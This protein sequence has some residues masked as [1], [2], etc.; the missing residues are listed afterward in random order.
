[1]NDHT[2]VNSFDP[3]SWYLTSDHYQWLVQVSEAL[4]HPP[5]S[6]YLHDPEVRDLLTREAR[7]LDDQAYNE[8]LEL[9]TQ[10]CVYWVPASWPAGDPAASITLEFHDRRRLI[11][12]VT[13]LETGVA[14]SQI[15]PSRTARV[16]N[17]PE[18]W[19][20]DQDTLLARAAFVLHEFRQGTT[21]ALAGWYGYALARSGSHWQISVKQIN[22]IDCDC[23]QGNNSFF[24]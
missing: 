11:D 16:L 23:P 21:R 18:A 14:Y 7:L 6:G 3:A 5:A 10:E 1:M 15:P 17:P 19:M 4:K 22:L 24:L 12:R 8:W 2:R 9:F 20:L 13:R